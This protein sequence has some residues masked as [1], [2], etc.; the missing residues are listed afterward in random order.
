M[1][2]T[3]KLIA[4]FVAMMTIAAMAF[5]GFLPIRPALAD[6]TDTSSITVVNA[7]PGH[8]Y[9]AYRFATFSNVKAANGDTIAS[10]DVTTV[11]GPSTSKENTWVYKLN[12]ACQDGNDSV[13][14]KW[15]EAYDENPA[16]FMATLTGDELA[17]VAAN[18]T[19]P[20]GLEPNGSATVP[21]EAAQDLT[22]SNLTEGWYV[23]EDTGTD[24]LAIVATHITS[25]GTTY[26]KF[27]INE[28]T[29]QSDIADT[30]GRFYA[31]AENAQ[32]KPHKE[33]YSDAAH[34]HL[35][36]RANFSI[37]DTLYHTIDTRI[38]PHAANYD[39]YTFVIM[40]Q[41]SRGLTLPDPKD[42][43]FD[44]KAM[45]V[46]SADAAITSHTEASAATLTNGTDY[47]WNVS[48]AADKTTTMTITI[49]SP[50]KLKLAGKYLRVAYPATINAD[51]VKGGTYTYTSTDATT[52]K[53]S[54]TTE[55]LAENT[56]YNSARVN[57][58]N[59]GWTDRSVTTV[60]T[61][62][63]SFTKVGVG[64]DLTARAGVTFNLFRGESAEESDTN[65]PLTF[66]QVTV[67]KYNY[68]PSGGSETVTDL[69]TDANGKITV[70]GLAANKAPKP[71]P[72]TFKETST[73]T[74]K[75][76]TQSILATFTV[77]H[78]IGD[79]GDVTN[80]LSTTK[81]NTLGLATISPDGAI[82]VKNVKNV[83]QLPLTGAA[84][85]VLFTFL[86]LVLASI[87]ALLTMVY[88][89][90]RAGLDK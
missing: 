50:K 24:K 48:T 29:G 6:T 60:F 21:G 70:N 88:R 2:K 36:D 82:T 9:N 68:N 7:Q 43:K 5:A 11:S 34:T 41:A 59:Q 35:A 23:I 69:V 28:G 90:A 31:K 27:L 72:Y 74:A 85:V 56:A 75:G 49:T 81:N 63:I 46:M 77:D 3:R 58:N 54:D 20:E 32:S 78:A 16:A 45:K 17:S 57:A 1:N 39:G 84:G 33:V 65:K 12:T 47:S 52:G 19:L 42:P 37:G 67:G 66:D 53:T 8:T 71:A 83:T 55:D 10:M 62:S 80:T 61:G 76:Y 87:A 18:L 25:G 51:I 40:D 26:T 86:A 44:P 79:N 73:N 89:R 14:A 4:G 64:A 15:S 13:K 38:S 30:L 22:I